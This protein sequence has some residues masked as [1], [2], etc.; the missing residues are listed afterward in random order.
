MKA[1]VHHSYTLKTKEEKN[2]TVVE[3]Y[4]TL[5]DWEM[6]KVINDRL[7][8]SKMYIKGILL[9][10]TSMYGNYQIYGRVVIFDIY[11]V[12]AFKVSSL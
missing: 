6:W 1:N 8:T 5:L 10:M 9:M 2:K 7:Q 11:F 12:W 4:F 3:L